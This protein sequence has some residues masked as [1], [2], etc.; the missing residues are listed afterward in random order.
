VEYT[1]GQ[2]YSFSATNSLI[3]NLK[4][5]PS[6]TLRGAYKYKLGAMQ[7]CSRDLAGG[8]NPAWL[9]GATL[10][11]VPPSKARGHPDYDDRMTVVCRNIAPAVDVREIVV[12]RNSLAAAHESTARPS[13]AELLAAY[14]I[15]E[16]LTNPVPQRIGIV[17]DVLTAGTHYIAVKTVLG[18]RFLGVPIVGFF[19]ARRVFPNSLDE[20]PFG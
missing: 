6:T 8:I 11:P 17:D 15:D 16:T 14:D 7:T 5:K 18:R 4:K 12:Q 3:S 13:I 2:N 19:L 1:S 20:L 9:N 10:I